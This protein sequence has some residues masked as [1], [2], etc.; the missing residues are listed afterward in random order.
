MTDMRRRDVLRYSAAGAVTAATTLFG[1]QA[2]AS[3][4]SA[5]EPEKAAPNDP[6]DFDET[7]KGKKIKGKH[8]IGGKDELHINNQKLALTVI[9]TLF[10]PEDGSEPYVAMAY[11]SAINHYD[12]VEIDDSKNKGGLKKLAQKVIDMLGDLELSNEAAQ[13][14]S[15]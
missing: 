4:N 3:P 5:R 10:V 1:V 15:H 6:R 13:A 14:H 9:S 12:P 11:I 7:Y 2:L 8:N